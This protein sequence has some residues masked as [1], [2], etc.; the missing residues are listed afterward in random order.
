M[1]SGKIIQSLSA[2]GFYTCDLSHKYAYT[3]PNYSP[4]EIKRSFAIVVLSLPSFNSVIL[5]IRLPK[6][7]G[8]FKQTQLP[9]QG[10]LLSTFPVYHAKVRATF[11]LSD[12]SA[13]IIDMSF[14][15]CQ[16][17]ICKRYTWSFWISTANC[18]FGITKSSYFLTSKEITERDVHLKP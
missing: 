11:L 15:N 9:L 10:T 7:Q 4:N 12:C 5:Q 6:R 2:P 14:F 8:C 17:S 1:T 18:L 13:W 16:Q 3:K